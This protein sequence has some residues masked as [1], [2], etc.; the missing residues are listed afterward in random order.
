VAYADTATVGEFVAVTPDPSDDVVDLIALEG[1]LQALPA[2]DRHLI[3]LR[4]GRG[5]TQ[6]EIGDILGCSQMQICRQLRRVNG[7]LR[8]GM[9][10]T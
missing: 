6:Q 9:G 2:T 7:R 5:L 10:A 1:L 3:D 8:T 4:F